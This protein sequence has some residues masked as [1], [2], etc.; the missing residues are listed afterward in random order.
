MEGELIPNEVAND[1]AALSIV[2]E[3]DELSQ[4]LGYLTI[5]SKADLDFAGPELRQIVTKRDAIKAKYDELRAPFAE[6][7]ARLKEFF[8]QPLKRLDEAERVLKQKITEFHQ[9]ESARAARER[10]ESMLDADSK[11][12]ELADRVAELEADSICAATPEDAERLAEEAAEKRHQLALLESRAP[13]A[14]EPPPSTDG[15][16]VRANWQAEVLDIDMLWETAYKDRALRSLFA[17]DTKALRNLAKMTK[18][19]VSYPGLHFF[20][21]GTV[22]ARRVK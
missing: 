4:A 15:V 7:I 13:A 3:A 14:I 9:S 6:G 17:V 20:N 21:K 10:I 18:G 12:A 16:S 8:D 22:A 2:M 5:T 1:G 19:K 11:I